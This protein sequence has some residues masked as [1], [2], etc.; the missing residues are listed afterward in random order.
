MK[1]NWDIGESELSGEDVDETELGSSK[2][3]LKPTQH[4][5]PLC[6]SCP[7]SEHRQGKIGESE[8]AS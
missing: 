4:T 8:L 2:L 3:N 6:H 5:R 1:L 7:V